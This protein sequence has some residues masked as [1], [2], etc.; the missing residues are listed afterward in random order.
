MPITFLPGRSWLHEA[1]HHKTSVLAGVLAIVSLSLAHYAG[2]LMKVPLQIVAVAGMPLAKGVT[3]T[4][5]FY[6]FF[7]AVFARV[8]ASMLQLVVLP[9]LAVTDR[10]ER[11]F[12][13]RMDWPHQRRFVRSH[14][15]TIKW[16]GYIWIAI[17]ALLFLLLMLAIYVKFTITWISGV[18][19][20][21]SIVLIVLSGLVRSGF[22]LQPIPNTFIRKIKSRPARSGHVA[23]AAFVTTTAALIIV[24]F[25]MGS[26]RASLLRDQGP[27]MIVTKEFTGMAT[28]IASSEGAILLFQKQDAELRYIY[29]APE[30]TASIETKSVFP[31]IGSKKE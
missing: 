21:T 16:E 2:F 27:H 5:L 18:G 19:L 6:V 7:C 28:V 14:S 20:L 12:R 26:M 3:A 17:Q 9:F 24:A 4:F 23:S 31:P 8:L 30:F 25:F 15:Q 22:F 29:S 13:R 1:W 10:L 11:G